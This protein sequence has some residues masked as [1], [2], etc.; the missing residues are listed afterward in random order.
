MPPRT[1]ATDAD[2]TSPAGPPSS[3]PPPEPVAPSPLH[4]ASEASDPDV[5]RLLFERQA[6][7]GPPVDQAALDRIA[8]ELADLGYV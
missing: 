7:A 5:H 1:R 2:A 6:A 3:P 8:G 4:P